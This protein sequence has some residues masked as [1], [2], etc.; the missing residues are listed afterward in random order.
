VYAA[1]E[2]M[3]N[4]RE[5]LRVA[6]LLDAAPRTEATEALW[7]FVATPDRLDAEL[8]VSPPDAD[9]VAILVSRLGL[10]AVDALLDHLGRTDDRSTRASLMKQL[11]ALGSQMGDVAVA[12]L[13]HAPW[14]LQR[15]ILVLIGR[16]RSWPQGFSPLSYAA[17]LDPRIRREG[18]K[19]LLESSAHMVEGLLLGLRDSDHGVVLLALNAALESCPNEAISLV[20][21]IAVDPGRPQDV[22]MTSLRVLS[23]SRSPEALKV[24]LAYARQR[25]RWFGRRLP[26]K[27]PELLAALS[28]LAVYWKDD[29]RA[30]EVLAHAMRHSDPEIR[31]AATA[32]A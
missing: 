3:L 15:N 8:A 14:H 9:A 25:R 22:R 27:S 6:R 20:A 7:R 30:S 19:L 24:L 4:R 18:I 32:A 10:E 5:L 29:P 2:A 16:L 23:R 26:S 31:A 11:L 12:R 1:A 28:A 21:T 17:H 13:P